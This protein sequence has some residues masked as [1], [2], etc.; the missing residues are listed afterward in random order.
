[1]AVFYEFENLALGVQDA[2]YEP[3]DIRK[4]LERCC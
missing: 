4:V 1:M 2:K 3:F